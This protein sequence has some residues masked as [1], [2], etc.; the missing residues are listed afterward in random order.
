MA[1]KIGLTLARMARRA[2]DAAGVAR[3]IIGVSRFSQPGAREQLHQL[4]IET[5]SCNLLDRA[6]LNALPDAPNVLYLAAMKFGS[7]GQEDLTWA[8]NV[9]LPGMVAE[10]YRRS[11]IV[12][13][14][15][16]NVYAMTP[17]QGGSVETDLPA[18][19]GDYAMSVLGRER[20][21]T[22]ASKSWDT[23]TSL[24]RLNYA[25]E[26]RYGVL[27]DIGQQVLAGLPVDLTMGYLN[28]IWQGDSNAMTLGALEHVSSPP[29]IINLAGP[30]CL[31]VRQVA[32]QFGQLLGK[33]VQFS[34]QESPVAFLSNAQLSY[35]L[36][37]RPRV[38]AEQMIV[39]IADWL[40]RGGS[41][42][43]KPTHFQ[44]RDGKF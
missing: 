37:G 3:R 34:G 24:I 41:T 7:T 22:W 32:E 1:G 25:T 39:W 33:P 4:G 23:P 14:S 38:T 12:A 42:L 8:M 11:R 36:F 5:I 27:V 31:S 35:R 28:S 10:K 16:G 18:P 43:G 30:E 13:Y 6:E 2:S 40:A 19:I 9:Y 21:F 44:T 26:L 15:S 20:I 17:R 29:S